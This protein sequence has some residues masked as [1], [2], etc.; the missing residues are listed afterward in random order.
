MD[1][2]ERLIDEADGYGDGPVVV[3]DIEGLRAL[4]REAAAALEAAREDAWQPIETAPKDGALVLLCRIGVTSTWP[5]WWRQRKAFDRRHKT[6]WHSSMNSP[7][8]FSPTH[9]MP[10]PAPPKETSNG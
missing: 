9:W 4:L 3:H 2:I 10:L 5:A 7:I 1:L 6:G 8:K